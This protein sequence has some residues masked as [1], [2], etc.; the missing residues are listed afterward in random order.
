ME[1]KLEAKLEAQAEAESRA[2]LRQFCQHKWE[3]DGTELGA[4]LYGQILIGCDREAGGI[5]ANACY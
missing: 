5:V 3:T 1:Y 2:K 4:R